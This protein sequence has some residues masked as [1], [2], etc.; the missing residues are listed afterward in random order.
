MNPKHKQLFFADRPGLRLT[1]EA[2]HLVSRGSDDVIRISLPLNYLRGIV[3]SE[4]C[5]ISASLIARCMRVGL[6]VSILF[7]DGS[8]AGRFEPDRS[9]GIHVRAM[10]FRI[11][12][13]VS[14][15]LSMAKRIVRDKIL[16]QQ[17]LL[18]NYLSNH[19]V[20]AVREA[21]DKIRTGLRS[22]E[23]LNSIF[24][25]MGCEGAA[26]AAYWCA[27]SSMIRGFGFRLKHPAVD[28]VNAMLSFGYA[29]LAHEIAAVA[30]NL[31]FDVHLA[32]LHAKSDHKTV[33]AWDLM[34][35]F[36][37]PLVDRV[38]LAGFNRRRYRPE[39]FEI[40]DGSC[41]LGYDLKKR[42]LAD[43]YENLTT[44]EDS[45]FD[46]SIMAGYLDSIVAD[47]EALNVKTS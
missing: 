24:A 20:L 12:A 14:A 33:L 8:L 23:K 3:I 18:K 16:S 35:P 36:R 1:V 4:G 29:I 40:K 27:F 26:A 22:L 19:S 32:F 30:D 43:F 37:A 46:R 6:P 17:T 11:A 13:D 41:R 10:Q 7:A 38:V 5:G 44:K 34:E 9:T 15:R 47:M 28:P 31:G 42:F 25:L 45:C 39:D 2:E 21:S